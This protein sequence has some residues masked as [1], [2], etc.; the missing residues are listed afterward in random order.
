MTLDSEPAS[1][2]KVVTL[3][4]CSV[5]VCVCGR[6]MMYAWAKAVGGTCF[7]AD[8]KQRLRKDELDMTSNKKAKRNCKGVVGEGR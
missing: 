7:E 8:R 6:E 1:T 5:C 4:C 2:K 3:L